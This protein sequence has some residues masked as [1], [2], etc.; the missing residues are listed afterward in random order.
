MEDCGCS[1]VVSC[2]RSKADSQNVR[3]ERSHS[4]P[5]FSDPLADRNR[6]KH[7]DI[8]RRVL[9]HEGRVALDVTH[10]S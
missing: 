8:R 7:C 6:P 5:A 9:P 4:L 3:D 1:L 10:P 2:G